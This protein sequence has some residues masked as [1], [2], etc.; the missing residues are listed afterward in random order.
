MEDLLSGFQQ[1]SPGLELSD[2]M[3]FSSCSM[4]GQSVLG[5]V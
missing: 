5:W 4:S 3:V 2:Y 1:R